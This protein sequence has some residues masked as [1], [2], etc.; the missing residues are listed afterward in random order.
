[1]LSLERVLAHPRL[2][3]ALTGLSPAEFTQL[4]PAVTAAWEQA[5][6]TRYISTPTRQRKPGGGRKGVV[7]SI[8][9]KLFFILCYYKCYPTFDLLGFLYGCNRSNACRREQ[10][11]S[12]LLEAALGRQ[13]V[14]PAR[15]LHSPAEFFARFPE[16]EAVFL[17]GTER[18]TQRPQDPERQR[19]LY[20]GKRKRH[21]RKNL[22]L[23]DAQR[24][25][26]LL[27]PTVEGT[28]HD[29]ALLQ[30]VGWPQRIPKPIVLH[31][32]LGF[33]GIRQTYPGHTVSI[34]AKKPRGQ[35]LTPAAKGWNTRRRRLRVVVEHA[36]AGVKRFRIVAD[37]FRNRR[38]TLADRAMLV[39]C[40]LWNYHL[41]VG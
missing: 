32:D 13:L 8:A 33:Q 24:R 9:E 41:A 10:A 40:G 3:R 23:T 25:I 36:L 5:Q 4:L 15:Q 27:S 19:Q 39:A 17:D 18:P 31:V 26:G 28:R 20:S 30:A 37:V 35:P 6:S 29:F 12:P 7:P 11:L 14:L 21:T 1:M 16:A 22:I 2:M 34:P 38:E